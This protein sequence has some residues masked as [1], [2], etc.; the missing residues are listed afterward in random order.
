M[1]LYNYLSKIRQKYD[2]TI[3]LYALCWNEER[4]LPYFF[5]HY[6]HLITQYF[7]FDSGSTDRSIEM[8]EANRKV[9]QVHFEVSGDSFVDAARGH[10]NE[11]WKRSRGQ[12]DWVIVCN[13]DEHIYHPNLKEYLRACT[14]KGISLIIPEGYNMVSDAFPQFDQPLTEII[15]YGM[16]DPVWDKPQIFNPNKIIEM[17]F[18]PG[19]HS[20]IPGGE[21]ASP[22]KMEVKLLHFKYLGLEYLIGRHAQLRTGLRSRDIEQHWGEQYLWDEER[23]AEEYRR[24]KSH[25]QRVL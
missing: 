10:Y 11:C 12:A 6:D 22:E 8:L 7:I 24:V 16:R 15:N 9:N 21:V 19:R 25:A 13:I 23:N 1:T 4:M 5:R 17:N 20:A 2:I 18:A 14:R 3:H